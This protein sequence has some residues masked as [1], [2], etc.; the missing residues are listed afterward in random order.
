MK[1]AT[2]YRPVRASSLIG[3]NVRSAEDKSLGEVRDLIVN[4]DTGDVRYAIL[5]FD[6]GIFKSERL[7]AGPAEGPQHVGR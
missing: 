6:P 2:G 3:K 5:E 4:M 7:F 1:P